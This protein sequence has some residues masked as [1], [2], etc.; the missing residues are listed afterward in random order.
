M[1][2]KIDLTSEEKYK[3]SICIPVYNTDKDLFFDCL[4]SIKFCGLKKEEFEIVVIDDG[5]TEYDVGNFVEEFKKN[6]LGYNIDCYK[7]AKNEGLLE[8][9]R[10]G[11][12]IAKGHY[13]YNL[14]SDDFL[15]QNTLGKVIEKYYD[16][17]YDM[18]QMEYID[19]TPIYNDP[20]KGKYHI[21]KFEAKISDEN[22]SLLR[23]FALSRSLYGYIWGKLIKRSLYKKVF[24]ILPYIRL[25]YREDWIQMFFLCKYAKSILSLPEYAVQ[26]YRRN[27]MTQ[28]GTNKL[29]EK[30]LENYLSY[31]NIMNIVNPNN[32]K[33]KDL[34]NWI[35][36]IHMKVLLEIYSAIVVGATEEN[37]QEYTKKFLDTFG[38]ETVDIV[39]KL[40]MSEMKNIKK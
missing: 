7:H 15:E 40:Y 14:D 26:Y 1:I 33:T 11:V 6:N 19:L 32:A 37:K 34:K 9:R 28:I 20:S 10:S 3:V 39:H 29:S 38:K 18:I 22:Q 2:E 21:T 24:D 23:Y 30:Q 31:V 35:S 17:D 16:Q 4:D 13:I 27:G 25:N 8:A 5:S 36:G 12:A